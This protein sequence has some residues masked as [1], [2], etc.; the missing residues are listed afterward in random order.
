MKLVRVASLLLLALL[1][2]FSLTPAATGKECQVFAPELAKCSSNCATFCQG[3]YGENLIK[4]LHCSLLSFSFC[5]DF[6]ELKNVAAALFMCFG[7]RSHPVN[8]SFPLPPT[9]RMRDEERQQNKGERGLIPDMENNM[10]SGERV[11]AAI[12]SSNIATKD[13]NAAAKNNNGNNY[14]KS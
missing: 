6:K 7:I 10:E 3:A 11:R 8:E 12:L 4:S 14:C 9:A 1:L 5:S 2:L 13:S